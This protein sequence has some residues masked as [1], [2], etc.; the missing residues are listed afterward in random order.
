[1]CPVPP[2]EKFNKLTKAAIGAVLWPTTVSAKRI[3]PFGS[4]LGVKINV[5]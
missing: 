3:E 5:K 1:M 2:P 4:G